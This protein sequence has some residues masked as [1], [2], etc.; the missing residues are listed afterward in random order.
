[1]NL[2]KWGLGVGAFLLFIGIGFGAVRAAE[3]S[4]HWR[5][6]PAADRIELMADP[7]TGPLSQWVF[8]R[9]QWA[10]AGNRPVTEQPTLM[11]PVRPGRIWQDTVELSGPDAVA[12]TIRLAVPPSPAFFVSAVTGNHV[13]ILST[14]PLRMVEGP[15]R[16]V[17]SDPREI[18]LTRSPISHVV[19]LKV[20]AQSGEVAT[21][22]VSI[23]SL[24][25][26][27]M[28]WFGSPTG[29]RVYLTIDDGWFPSNTLLAFMQKTHVPITAFLIQK[30]AAEHPAYW[31]AFVQAGGIIEDHTMSHPFLT[32]LTFAG[33]QAQWAGPR[34]TFPQWFGVTPTLGRPPYGAVDP[35]VLDAAHAA[36]LQ[37]IIMWDVEW[38]P[39]KGFS[40]WNHGPIQPGA[41]I[42]LHWVPGVG[43]AVE[44]LVQELAKQGLHPAPLPLGLPPGV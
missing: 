37:A 26:I 42:L 22:T 34:N 28:I 20:Q 31:K 35:T 38:T 9:T 29:N 15:G 8:S 5:W 30:A 19:H 10:A 36:G 4:V 16:W 27:P 17:Q 32:S 1:M 40:T 6:V 2:G 13:R 23:P 21:W 44:T 7:G 24:A 18:I 43:H 14:Q 41:I 33:A 3:P 39:S 11:V 12:Q 25:T